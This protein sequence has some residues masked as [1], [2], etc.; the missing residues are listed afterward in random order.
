MGRPPGVL[1]EPRIVAVPAERPRPSRLGHQ[2]P[3]DRLVKVEVIRRR[4]GLGQ[5]QF[6]RI[7][8]GGDDHDIPGRKR[9]REPGPRSSPLEDPSRHEPPA[10]G[11]LDARPSDIV[12]SH[13]TGEP[14]D[15]RRVVLAAVTGCWEGALTRANVAANATSRTGSP[16]SGV[17][18]RACLARDRL[19]TRAQGS[20]ATGPGPR[21]CQSQTPT[22]GVPAC[23]STK[24]TQRQR[25][26]AGS[27]PKSGKSTAGNDGVTRQIVSSR[28]SKAIL[29]TRPPGRALAGCGECGVRDSW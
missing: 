5:D 18:S 24:S 27:R 7:Y 9:G 17:I 1:V 11:P 16:P 28:E 8:L 14:H 20:A 25:P 12:V 3:V 6:S 19:P 13:P 2:G 26:A 10:D 4:V 29:S 21:P 23:P 15:A 22:G